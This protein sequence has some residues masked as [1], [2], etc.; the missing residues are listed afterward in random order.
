[1]SMHTTTHT[2]THTHTDRVPYLPAVNDG[3]SATRH[4]QY[5]GVRHAVRTIIRQ[6]GYV[7]L[8]RVSYT[9]AHRHCMS[10]S[11]SG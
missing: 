7:G 8:Y 2:H 5:D 1:M 10:T 11:V 4:F 9:S 6:D 3:S